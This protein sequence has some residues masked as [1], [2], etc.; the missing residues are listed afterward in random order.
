MSFN[1]SSNAISSIVERGFAFSVYASACRARAWKHHYQHSKPKNSGLKEAYIVNTLLKPL[2]L[3][4]T[5]QIHRSTVCNQEQY[6][7]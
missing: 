3:H 6:P 2:L 5:F 7:R 4:Q 1:V